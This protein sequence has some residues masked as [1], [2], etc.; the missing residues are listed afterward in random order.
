M[1]KVFQHQFLFAPR[2][3]FF[4]TSP[5]LTPT[6]VR[7]CAL[8]DRR[9]FINHK[10]RML[11]K[12]LLQKLWGEWLL[13][14]ASQEIEAALCWG[15]IFSFLL[16]LE[17]RSTSPSPL[18]R[19]LNPE[20]PASAGWKMEGFGPLLWM[21]LQYTDGRSEWVSFSF[22]FSCQQHRGSRPV[23]RD[24]PDAPVART[25]QSQCRGAGLDSWSQLDHEHR[26]KDAECR[27]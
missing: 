2:R 26:N 17:S 20:A 1:N 4:P 7:T 16:D 23:R 13:P 9:T 25:L 18:T 8:I 21:G 27:S 10:I 3:I 11:K 24:F 5:P 15:W 19:G 14:L 6:T 22:C 12:W